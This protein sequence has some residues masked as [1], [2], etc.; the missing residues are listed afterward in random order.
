MADIWKEDTKNIA[1]VHASNSGAMLEIL[2]Y[3]KPFELIDIR[4]H[5]NTAPTTAENFTINLDAEA[6]S[7]FDVNILTVPMAG[8]K[9]EALLEINMKFE[10]GDKIVF[11]WANTDARTWGLTYRYRRI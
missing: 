3:P 5:V 10:T 2:D 11:A 9:D 7:A 4:L 1:T 6:G 8:V